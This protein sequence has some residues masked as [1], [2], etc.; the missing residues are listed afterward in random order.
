MSNCLAVAIILSK[1]KS[2]HYKHIS[3]KTA[4][5][6]SDELT[7][8][9]AAQ[10][11]EARSKLEQQAKSEA[12]VGRCS[13]QAAGGREMLRKMLRGV[14]KRALHGVR[15]HYTGGRVLPSRK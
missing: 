12:E 1:R 15:A 3:E 14:V 8:I 13:T 6:G 5:K 7:R 2:D 4:R 10:R 11:A 9:K